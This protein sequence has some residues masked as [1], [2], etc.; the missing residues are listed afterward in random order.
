MKFTAAAATA[1]PQELRQNPRVNTLLVALRK[2]R[3]NAPTLEAAQA[4]ATIA[5]E[6]Y[7]DEGAR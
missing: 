3:D 2:V 7:V 4:L 5:I 1:A 6:E